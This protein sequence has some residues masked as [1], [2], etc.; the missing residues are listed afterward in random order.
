MVDRPI[1]FSA[2]MVRALLAGTKTQT[3]RILKP[4]PDGHVYR[5]GW[6]A[7]RGAEWATETNT[8]RIPIWAG[9]R[10]WVKE[11]WSGAHAFRDVPPSQRESFTTPDGPVLRED[12]WYWADG[13]PT[14]GD[15]EKPRPSLFMPRWASRVTL[16]IDDV[17][18][19]RL[20]DITYADAIAEGVEAHDGLDANCMGYRDYSDPDRGHWVNSYLSYATLWDHINGDGA[21]AA[22]HWV[23]A[24]SFRTVLENIDFIGRSAA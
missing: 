22:N 13:N 7:D 18:V 9:D 8:G 1:L 11:K 23:V 19:E 4:Q 6:Y 10:L 15:Y 24:Y 5:Y 14:G 12:I 2:P 20:Q 16:I 21:W 17:K 3:R